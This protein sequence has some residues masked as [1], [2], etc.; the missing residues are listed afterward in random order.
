MEIRRST[1]GI[2]IGSILLSP[3]IYCVYFDY[4]RRHSPTFRRMI[5]ELV[6]QS[7]KKEKQRRLQRYKELIDKGLQKAPIPTSEPEIA[8][9]IVLNLTQGENHCAKGW[10]AKCYE[11]CNIDFVVG[12]YEKAALSYYFALEAY[13]SPHELM[14]SVCSDKNVRNIL[15]KLAKVR[16]F[17][18]SEP[19]YRPTLLVA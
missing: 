15:R 11:E 13:S 7:R 9:Y 18:Q 5:R 12:Q 3:I 8:Q 2:I 17:K 19:R 4:R 16:P 14:S 6:R 1:M 10:F